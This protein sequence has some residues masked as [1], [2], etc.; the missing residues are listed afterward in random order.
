MERIVHR[1]SGWAAMAALV[2]LGA[3]CAQYATPRRAADMQLFGVASPEQREQLTDRKIKEVLARQPL[4]GFPAGIAVARVQEPGYK[5]H[6]TA[7]FGTG[8]Y[9][10]VLTRD[11]EQD[12]DLDRLARMP[13]V[14]GLAPINRLLLPSELH[15][16]REL[17]QAA[18]SL[19][20]DVLLIYTFDTSIYI[21]HNTSPVDVVTLGFL[22]HKQARVTTTASAAL[23][24]T[25]NGYLYGVAEAS[26]SHDQPANTWTTEDAVDQSR[27]RTE[28]EAFNKLVGELEK[29]WTGVLHE[30]AVPP[31]G[32]NES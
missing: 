4:A 30:Y 12:E 10:V 25:R 24:D 16:D 6:H 22:P 13:M 21:G 3:G 7:A 11:V 23:L 17:R 20:A 27:R 26:A 9:S 8:Q 19:H 18:A 29:T 1:A 31:A 14:V 2:L 5:T 15:D 28:A 32:P